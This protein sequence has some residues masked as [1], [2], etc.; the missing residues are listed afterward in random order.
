MRVGTRA[1]LSLLRP[2]FLIMEKKV[3]RVELLLWLNELLQLRYTKVE[4][5]GSGAA[6]CQIVDS[7]FGDVPL[8]RVKFDAAHEHEFI[9]NYKILQQSFD[10]HRVDKEI[11]VQ[12]LIKRR[13]TDNYDFLS[14]LKQ[15]WEQ[16]YGGGAY[17]ASERRR[18][19]LGLGSRMQSPRPTVPPVSNLPLA[20]AKQLP[21]SSSGKG[22]KHRLVSPV[23]HSNFGASPLLQRTHSSVTELMKSVARLQGERDYYYT[24]LREIEALYN[25]V[26]ASKPSPPSSTSSTSCK[27]SCF[28]SVGNGQRAGAPSPTLPNPMPLYVTIPE[29]LPGM[30]AGIYSDPAEFDETETF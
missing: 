10:R 17:N 1:R 24:K 30:E 6:Y 28:R 22:E 26:L 8:G 29:T 13:F 20:R 19:K 9:A 27:P 23:N 2:G 14:W 3:A 12:R 11:P 25:A 18:G 4:E 16:H 15:F 21:Q 7:I 5:A